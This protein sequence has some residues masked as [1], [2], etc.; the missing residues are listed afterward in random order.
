MCMGN[1]CTSYIGAPYAA[2]RLAGEFNKADKRDGVLGPG[3]EE[4]LQLGLPAVA[5]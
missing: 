2:G 5:G 3:S 4:W 1:V